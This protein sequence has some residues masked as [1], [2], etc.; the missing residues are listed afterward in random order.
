MNND[1]KYSEKIISFDSIDDEIFSEFYVTINDAIW[2]VYSKNE[3]T[4]KNLNASNT[5]QRILNFFYQK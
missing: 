5:N 3:K 4:Q 1:S 2:V